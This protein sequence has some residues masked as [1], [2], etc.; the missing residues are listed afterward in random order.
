M[1]RIQSLFAGVAR[2]L[3][4]RADVEDEV[5]DTS[6]RKTLL[7]N[8]GAIVLNGL[9]FP[10]AGKILGAGLLLA[11]FL[12]ELKSPLFLIG[13]LIPIQYGLALLAQPWIGQWL[14]GK[15]RSAPYY[16]AQA[17][18]RGAAVWPWRPGWLVI[19]IGFC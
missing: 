4:V 1:N 6:Q 8:F 3:K 16:R 9:F 17:L 14:S 2:L 5:Q 11:W 12:D 7:A 18:L 19:P 10:T 13:L 15:P